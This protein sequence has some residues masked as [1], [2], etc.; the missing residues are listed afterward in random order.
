MVV[1]C[2]GI[3]MCV[4]FVD[5]I[6]WIVIKVKFG[7]GIQI[8]FECV[9]GVEYFFVVVGVVVVVRNFQCLVVVE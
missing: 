9:V 2:C 8:G 4:G 6:L 7:Y 3:Q 1:D 5:V